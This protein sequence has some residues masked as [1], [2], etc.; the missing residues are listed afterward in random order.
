MLLPTLR[1][2][3]SRVALVALG[4]VAI[5][6]GLFGA[7][8]PA[9]AQEQALTV[10]VVGFSADDWPQPQAIVTVEDAQG[11]P[12]TD[13]DASAFQAYLNDAAAP[14]TAVTRAVDGSLPIAVVLA[15]D[16][17][18]SM[19]GAALDQAKAAASGFLASLGPLDT[20]AVVTF[21]DDVTVVQPFT[22]DRSAAG[23]VIAGLAARGETALYDA[24]SES[25]RLAAGSGSSRRAVVLLSDGLDNGSQLSRDEALAA[26]EELGVPVFAIGLGDIDRA[27]LSAL[28]D[29]TGG[30]FAETPSPAG[31]AQLYGQVAERL[32]GQYVVT[33]NGSAFG[34]PRA[35]A[36]T[37]GVDVAAG[38]LSG[39]GERAICPQSVCVAIPEVADGGRIE[40]ARTVSAQV[41]TEEA[42][43]S[44]RFLVDGQALATVADPPYEFT[45]DPT[46]LADGE[47]AL[48][49]EVTTAS[50]SSESRQISVQL[51][52]AAAGGSSMS[53]GLIAI[54][55]VVIVLLAI[56]A[57]F[58]LRRRGRGREPDGGPVAIPKPPL[59]PKSEVPI[60]ERLEKERIQHPAPVLDQT[61]GLLR[62]VGGPLQGETFTLGSNPISL[63]SGPRCRI[64]LEENADGADIP[65]EYARIW[66]RDNKLMVHELRR[67]TAIGSVGGRW[68]ILE[69]GE[70]FSVGPYTFRFELSGDEVG[71]SGTN[72][73]NGDVS[74][75]TANGASAPRAP[76]GAFGE[77]PPVEPKAPAGRIWRDWKPEAAG[78]EPSP[79]STHQPAP[80]NGTESLEEAPPPDVPNILRDRPPADDLSSPAEPAAADET[81]AANV[82]FGA[83]PD[84]SVPDAAGEP[85]AEIPNI[86]RDRPGSVAP[87]SVDE[88]V[89]DEP[90]AGF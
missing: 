43:T 34:G 44:V 38:G 57:W 56:V 6:T 52:A 49:V 7:S 19:N 35:D 14:V 33:L 50:G 8:A 69:S 27:Y 22:L 2:A 31:L 24:T 46:T 37:L 86:L 61:R 45:I 59:A 26:A 64:R 72:G 76:T 39:S 89:A 90:P 84:E 55:A 54:V 85:E 70:M 83:A 41:V 1:N 77:A 42:V 15:L 63:G 21:S 65:S 81:T 9:S 20:V 82:L 66:I 75:K 68:E 40:T 53:L 62:V 74:G 13:L 60:L 73:A 79:P 25:A 12:V 78:T 10:N 87:P 4:L 88:D 23:A 5:A 3:G 80:V 67:L 16:V 71:P 17:S 30:Q 11:Q 47:H 29:A 51:G 58:V 36:A 18:G 48:S 32:R 28:A